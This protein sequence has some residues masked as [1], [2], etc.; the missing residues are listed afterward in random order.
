ML[1][2]ALVL[3]PF[4]LVQTGWERACFPPS[5]ASLSLQ[6][7][8]TRLPVSEFACVCLFSNSRGTV[9]DR[10]CPVVPVHA[11]RFL[12]PTNMFFH[13]Q[14]SCLTFTCLAIGK[15]ISALQPCFL[16]DQKGSIY[17]LS[18]GLYPLFTM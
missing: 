14:V 4:L 7:K 3:L 18:R 10:G 1:V 5:A 12:H 9:N 15:L 16:W 8:Q 13:A 2:F 11:D 6:S 17:Q